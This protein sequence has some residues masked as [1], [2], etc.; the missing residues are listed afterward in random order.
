MNGQK[1]KE[2]GKWNVK[3]RSL[4]PKVGT[5]GQR[6]ESRIALLF[7]SHVPNWWDVM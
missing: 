3:L 7:P 1:G 2:W 5:V 6:E 4:F